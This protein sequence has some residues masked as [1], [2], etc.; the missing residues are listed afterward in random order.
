MTPA[1][2]SG[3]AAR[4]SVVVRLASGLRSHVGGASTV[5]VVAAAGD[6]GGRPTVADVL[7]ALELAHPAI[8]RRARDET[9]ALRQHVNVFVGPD[10]IR[11]LDG[12]RTRVPDGV[13][14]AL[15]AAVSGG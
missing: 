2:A 13:E 1:A 7:D 3:G 6:R 14:V 4:G 5:V 12:L 9:G 11:D 10:H 15:L 8:G